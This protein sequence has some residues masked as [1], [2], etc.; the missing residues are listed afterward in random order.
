[1]ELA[2]AAAA[3]W[4][5]MLRFVPLVDGTTPNELTESLEGL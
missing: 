3:R 2:M 4:M 5:Q 1:M